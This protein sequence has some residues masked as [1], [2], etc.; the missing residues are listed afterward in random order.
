MSK[1]IFTALIIFLV[2]VGI[3]GAV[4][5]Q[6]V[7]VEKPAIYNMSGRVTAV[8]GDTMT[9]TGALSNRAYV[10]T[11]EGPAP[12][13]TVEFAITPETTFK[14]KVVWIAKKYQ[15]QDGVSE[16][17]T[18]TTFTSDGS[19]SDL[20]VG[21]PVTAVQGKEDLYKETKATAVEIKY[22]LTEYE[23]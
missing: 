16:P 20:K 18:P 3:S 5:Y 17:F 23:K 15:V 4:Y 1:T 2:A 22:E 11:K 8:S 12:E 14:K 7:R 9:V 19:L 21:M 6:K 10:Y 13:Q